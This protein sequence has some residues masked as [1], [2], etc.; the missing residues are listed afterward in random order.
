MWET[1]G[2]ILTSEVFLRSIPTVIVLIAVVCIMIKLN[3][4]SVHTEHVTIGESKDSLTERTIMRNQI[5]FAHGFIYSLEHKI[6]SLSKVTP[7]K[8]DYLTK[9]ILECIYDKVIEW[10]TLNHIEN[11]EAYVSCKQAEIDNVVYGLVT[12]DVFRTEE[13]QMRMHKWT[14]ELIAQLV[15]IRRLYSKQ[16]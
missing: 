11:T 16:K 10:I 9:Y 4:F 14:E 7:T 1:I 6:N 13:F 2:N 8:D 15:K 3:I 12:L 5:N